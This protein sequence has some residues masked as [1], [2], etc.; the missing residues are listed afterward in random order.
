MSERTLETELE[1]FRL[2]VGAAV[3]SQVAVGEKVSMAEVAEEN[4]RTA[5][6]VALH[7]WDEIHTFLMQIH[8]TFKQQPGYRD[9]KLRELIE[10]RERH[11]VK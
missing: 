11:V 7:Q 4:V 5:S 8:N 3:E 10:P 6:R 2:L 9:S 1:R